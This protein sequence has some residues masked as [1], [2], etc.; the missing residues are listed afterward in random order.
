MNKIV[1][2]GHPDSGHGEVESLLLQ[3][4]MSAAL[5][6]RREGML[7][8]EIT[9]TLCKAHGLPSVD[10][11]TAE[12]Q[13]QQLQ[14]G[15]VWHGM[16]LDLMLG[17][18][19]QPLWGWADAQSIFLLEYWASLDPK[20]TFVLVYDE[21]HRVLLQA[22]RADAEPPSGQTLQRLLDN[23]VA[24]NGA[25]LRFFLRHPGRCLLVHSQQ[26]RRAADHYLQQLQPLLDTPL[27][28][29]GLERAA[30]ANGQK[31]EPASDERALALGEPAGTLPT[32][33]ALAATLAG[34]ELQ[35]AERRM[36][37]VAAEHFLVDEL[38]ADHPAAL[39]MYA[40]LQSVANLPFQQPASR[41]GRS[42]AEA[43]GTL[44]RHRAFMAQ[45]VTQ[46][47]TE[48]LKLDE[49][50]AE[51]RQQ[52]A[53]AES[54]HEQKMKSVREQMTKL[55]N[56]LT[57]RDGQAQQ[58]A[59][60]N[61]LLLRQLHQLQEEME[62][63]FLRKQ[64]LEELATRLER[65]G[66]EKA[67]R[68]AQETAKAKAALEAQKAAFEKAAAESDK[69]NKAQHAERASDEKAAAERE[70]RSSAVQEENQLLLKQLHQ[71]QEE[72]ERYYL[73]NQ[74]LKQRVAPP[75][76]PAPSGA[77]DRIKRQL[78]YRLGEVMI[79]RSRSV[80]GW[81]G[82]PWALAAE[83]RAFHDEVAK[84]PA[85]KLPP[86]HKYRDAHEAERVKQHL[87]YR[88]G[89]TLL[90][91]GRSP[92]GWMRLPFALRRQVLE[93]RQARQGKGLK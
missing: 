86:I 77:A 80:G 49:R 7:P 22:A 40:E 42:A 15:A 43:W 35:E 62:R 31:L 48:Y 45:L 82:M 85:G 30:T 88:L 74:R 56:A 20:L 1:I 73:E 50:L 10:Q 36:D 46:V 25:L 65:E 21:P 58:Q 27:A 57:E 6:S 79:R 29:D 92:L 66:K 61:E 51:V 93:F 89:A 19:D 55:S 52:L 5:P 75:K 59:Q 9:A 72:L 32:K 33:L 67:E 23:W 87:S 14:V 44:V 70:K 8:Q 12:E 81:V 28:R 13:L 16:A 91:H 84:R 18:L 39:Q 41:G 47:H 78:S 71:V 11:V 17:N 37:S 68:L 54:E 26:V 64:E 83:V 3:C 38:L 4:G 24:Y 69:R 76:P 90:Q 2:V 63:Q 60:E 53:Q 34:V